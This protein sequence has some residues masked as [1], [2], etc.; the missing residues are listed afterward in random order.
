MGG[1][2]VKSQSS[3]EERP[4]EMICVERLCSMKD[5]PIP[6]SYLTNTKHEWLVTSWQRGD[7]NLSYSMLRDQVA[8]WFRKILYHVPDAVSSIAITDVPKKRKCCQSSW[9]KR[10]TKYRPENASAGGLQQCAIYCID[11]CDVVDGNESDGDRE[12]CQ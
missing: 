6:A 7:C 11:D 2:A 8:I 9:G 10:T 4:D 12:N 1:K 5:T 3:G